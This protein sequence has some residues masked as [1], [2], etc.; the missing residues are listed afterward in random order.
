MSR[1]SK[2]DMDS[3]LRLVGDHGNVFLVLFPANRSRGSGSVGRRI[4][5]TIW[6][7]ELTEVK[8]SGERQRDA[9]AGCAGGENAVG[10][11]ME[12]QSNAQGKCAVGVYHINPQRCTHQQVCGI[13]DQERRVGVCLIDNPP[14][15]KP[16][17][18]AYLGPEVR[19]T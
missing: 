7:S 18:I 10:L 15:A 13:T 14:S 12:F 5:P 11:R 2:W 17:P 3:P 9:E 8:R 1:W 16:I 6:G 4:H 19:W